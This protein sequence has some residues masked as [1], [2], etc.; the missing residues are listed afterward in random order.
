MRLDTNTD[1]YFE[2]LESLRHFPDKLMT[3]NGQFYYQLVEDGKFIL[4]HKDH[5]LMKMTDDE[6]V[7][8]LDDPFYDLVAE[9]TYA[10][11]TAK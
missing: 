11:A 6:F 3:P 4:L 7:A 1:G 2:N 9:V 10:A 5:P 8:S